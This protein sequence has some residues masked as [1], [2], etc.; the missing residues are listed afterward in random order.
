MVATILSDG[1]A[2]VCTTLR[3]T[4]VMMMVVMVASE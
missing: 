2:K 3:F 1:N 4:T